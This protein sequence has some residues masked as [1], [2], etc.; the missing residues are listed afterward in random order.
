MALALLGARSSGAFV[1]TLDVPHNSDAPHTISTGDDAAYTL[2]LVDDEM[3]K[4]LDGTSPAYYIRPGAEGEK[5]YVHHEGG[6]WCYNEADCVSRSQGDLGSS[7][8]YAASTTN[9]QGDDGTSPS[10]YLSADPSSNPLMHNWTSVYLKYC[11][12]ASFSGRKED[13]SA[14]GLYYRGGYALDALLADLDANQGLSTATDVVVSGCSAGGLATFLHVDEYAERYTSANV[15][16]MPDSGFFLD[17]DDEPDV[18]YEAEMTWVFTAQEAAGGV[19]K[20]CVAAHTATND[21]WMCM[22]AEHTAEHIQSPI[23]PLQSKY[24]SWQTGNVLS[25][26]ATED[27]TNAFGAEL[28]TRLINTVLDKPQNGA[29]LDACHHHCGNF[30]VMVTDGETQATAFAKWYNGNAGNHFYNQDQAY[31][32]DDCCSANP[33]A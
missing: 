19:D 22:F 17:W 4:C 24:D 16:G 26:W 27:A 11:D 13:T 20:D 12:G 3:G 21:T 7:Q 28:T 33:A 25:P 32:C 5:F 8:Y 6:G 18:N 31:P 9:P 23:F 15:V 1:H 30:N 29:F 10:G 2:T 14:T